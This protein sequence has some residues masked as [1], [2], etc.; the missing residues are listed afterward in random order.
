M[1]SLQTFQFLDLSDANEDERALLQNTLFGTNP[2]LKY[3]E[4]PWTNNNVGEQ[5]EL[6]EWTDTQ[7]GSEPAVGNADITSPPAASEGPQVVY[8]VPPPTTPQS[9]MTTMYPVMQTMPLSNVY[10]GNMTT[11]VSVHPGY[12]NSPYPHMSPPQ[13][14]YDAEAV[15]RSGRDNGSRR[16]G[17]KPLGKRTPLHEVAE[18]QTGHPPQTYPPPVFT[19]NPLASPFQQQATFY[20]L[21]AQTSQHMVHPTAQHATGPPLYMPGNVMYQQPMY[22]TYSAPHVMYSMSRA[23]QVAGLPYRSAPKDMANSPVT[24]AEVSYPSEPPCVNMNYQQPP[25]LLN[26]ISPGHATISAEEPVYSDVYQ[27][28]TKDFYPEEPKEPEEYHRTREF[29]NSEEVK[30]VSPSIEVVQDDVTSCVEEEF[31][32]VKDEKVSEVVIVPVPEV[33]VEKSPVCAKPSDAASVPTPPAPLASPAPIAPVTQEASAPQVMSV[34]SAKRTPSPQVETPSPV[35]TTPRPAGKSWASLFKPSGMEGIRSSVPPFSG[36]KPTARIDP[37][38]S[39][40]SPV[41]ANVQPQVSGLIDDPNLHRLGEFLLKYQLEHKACSLQPRGLTNR[42]NWCYINSTLQALLACPPFYNLMK[43]LPVRPSAPG[44]KS[45]TPIIDNIVQFV[46]EFVPLSTVARLGRK[47]KAQQRKDDKDA[48][49]VQYGAA[50]EPGY[51]YKILNIISTDTFKVEGRQEDAEEFLSCLLNALND[52]MLEVLKVVEGSTK[53]NLS[54][55]DIA[56]NGDASLQSQDE[57]DSEWKVMGPKNKGSITRRADFGRTP[58][59]DIFRGQLRSRVHRAGDHTT[60]S[61][62]PFFTLQL[63]IERAQ[64]V[65]EALDILVG[66]DQLEGV[67]CTKTNQEVE[68]WQQVT[69][70]DLPLVLVLHLKWFDYKLDGCSK[71]VKTVEFPIDLKLDGKIVSSTKKYGVKEKQY[72]L[73]AVVYHDGKEATKGHYITD[74]FHVGY[75][76]WVRYDDSVVTAVQEG[77][78]LRP[79]GPRVPYLLYYRRCDTMSPAPSV[80]P[81]IR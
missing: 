22:N 56:T 12:V 19:M 27:S 26:P 81:T 42:S 2:N 24:V 21:P 72:K 18:S 54:N 15:P 41:D 25:Q 6:P 28:T 5:E 74:V 55:G 34:R 45:P 50:F 49:E 30:E 57:D 3:P 40:E 7:Y 70:E 69:L 10:V 23:E 33:P 64:T 37:F 14:A 43:S 66:R 75:S 51:I 20:H 46:N 53:S 48:V 44:V 67:T 31:V 36:A 17:N 35:A 8:S 63:D 68:A 39:L 47:E 79:R 60:D 73:F 65:K 32:N 1:D 71:I 4:L 11:N 59:S 9:V 78:V 58:I 38:P 16:R 80:T 62:Q 61:V 76:S 29:Y 13:P 77:H 52:E